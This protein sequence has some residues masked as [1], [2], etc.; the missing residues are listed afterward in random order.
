MKSSDDDDDDVDDDDETSIHPSGDV[1]PVH[2]ALR[3]TPIRPL[4]PLTGNKDFTGISGKSAERAYRHRYVTTC[5]G[6]A[7]SVRGQVSIWSPTHRDR[8]PRPTLLPTSP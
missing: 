4:V 5:V 6:L 7:W 8:K 2:R 3:N 1:G